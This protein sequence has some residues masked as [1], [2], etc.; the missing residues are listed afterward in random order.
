[1]NRGASEA[2]RV[3]AS[4]DG[5]AYAVVAPAPAAGPGN[6]AGAPSAATDDEGGFV[7]A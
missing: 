2:A 1:M 4:T 7:V 5:T 3:A 6:W